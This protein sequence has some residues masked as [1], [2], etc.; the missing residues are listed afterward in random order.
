LNGEGEQELAREEELRESEERL[1]LAVE[2]AGF[3]IYHCDLRKGSAW[4]SHELYSLTGLTPDT[5]AGIERVRALT[6]PEDR[7]R[8]RKA[9]QAAFS[10]PGAAVFEEEFRIV[11][12]DTGATR[13]L[14]VRGRT[15]SGAEGG[16]PVT[17]AHTGIVLDVTERKEA[18][19]S[20]RLADRQKSEFLATVAHELRNPLAPIRNAAE[21]LHRLLGSHAE[22]RRPLSILNRQTSQ[23]GRLVD[24]LLDIARIEQGQIA[25]HEEQLEITEIIDQA[26]KIV[27]PFVREKSY[28]FSIARPPAR[29]YVLGDRVRLV[30]CVANLLQ[31]AAKYTNAGGEI[32]IAAWASGSKVTIE[33]QD[34][35]IGIAPDVL[36]QI[37]E[38]FVQSAQ[39]AD[40]AQGGLGSGL[41]IVRHLVELHGGSIEARSEG[42]G[43]GA[44]FT[45]RLWELEPWLAAPIQGGSVS[46]LRRRILIVDPD[47]DA[48]DSLAI[49]LKVEGYEIEVAYSALSGLE[50]AQRFIPDVVLLEVQL[51]WMNGCELARRIRTHAALGETRIVALSGSAESLERARG[52]AYARYLLKPIDPG[53][54]EQV[55]AALLHSMR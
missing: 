20:A 47:A 16:R 24:D 42:L 10:F 28:H 49:L 33:V 21:V 23:L 38:L 13:W 19:E 43:R 53:Q 50:A 40:R 25:L 5:P 44:T 48:A 7:E 27:E 30:Q 12:A 11:R 4:W 9:V 46:A 18:E 55:L 3:G 31:N 54:L 15:R 35:G 2:V 14:H 36:P 39:A 8:V 26:L 22:A 45:I 51:P 52:T 32:R 6:H 1:R 29:I 17:L 37:F 41:A 34:N